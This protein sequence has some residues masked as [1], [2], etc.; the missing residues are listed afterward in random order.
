LKDVGITSTMSWLVHAVFAALW[1]TM[2]VT[3]RHEF[4]RER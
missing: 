2:V 1:D 4:T 3:S